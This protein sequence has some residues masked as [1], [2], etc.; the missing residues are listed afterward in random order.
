MCGIAGTLNSSCFS[1]K[2]LLA[3]L[4]HRGP[5]G[6]GEFSHQGVNLFHARLSIQDLSP[7]GA[8]PMHRH[9]LSIVFNGEIYNHL[10]LRAKVADYPF[11]T[12]SDTETILALFERFGERSL[13]WMDGMFAL[14]ILDQRTHKLFL[15]RDRMG[16]KPLFY[17]QEGEEFLFASELNALLTLKPLQ[18]DHAKLSAFLRCGFFPHDGAPYQGVQSLPQGSYA[19]ID[20]HHPRPLS[21]QRYFDLLSLYQAPKIE[22]FEASKEAVELALKESVKNRLESSDLEVG[23]FLSGGID[24]S[25]ITALASF[26][27]PK[28]KTFTVAFEGAYDESSLAELVAKRYK[29]DHTTLHLNPSKLKEEVKGILA[30]YGR[31]FMDSSAIPSYYVSQ[32]AKKHLTVILNGDGA[33][34]LFGGYRRYV[35]MSHGWLKLARP[36]SLLLPLLPLPKEK[37]SLYNYLHRLLAMSR[38]RGLDF[39]LSATIDSFED[40]YAFSPNPHTQTLDQEITQILEDSSLSSLSKMLYLDSQNLLLSDLLPK[41]DIATMAHSLEG[42]SPF[43]GK[44]LLEVAPRIKD[45]YKIF[46]KSTKFILRE[47]AKKYLPHTLLEQPKRGFEVPLRAWVE[48]ELKELIFDSLSKNCLSRELIKSRFVD[49]LL[50]K[51]Q[52]FAPEK[53]AKMLWSLFSLEVW[54]EHYQKACE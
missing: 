9:H 29:T 49:A 43:L 51:P 44:A 34:E 31:P 36:L 8:Q 19:F 48:G 4:A 50:N 35:P 41:M 15:A 39:Y 13:E 1:S 17:Y 20:L 37:K 52:D 6:H 46:G 18:I 14:A 26:F 2:K 47:L 53:R 38:K 11:S 7:A 12:R 40:A 23:S 25:L 42:R 27:T 33:D 24:S 54:Y 10:E 5:S 30:R 28:L 16:K 32:E 3:A 21:P 22:G 45:E